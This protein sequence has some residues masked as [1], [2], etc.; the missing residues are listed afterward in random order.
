MGERVNTMTGCV[1]RGVEIRTA[2]VWSRLSFASAVTMSALAAAKAGFWP[3]LSHE[4]VL[5]EVS[6][7]T[8]KVLASVEIIMQGT[9][10]PWILG[11]FLL[12]ASVVILQSGAMAKWL[13]W[14]GVVSAAAFVF[15]SVWL[16]TGNE[17][18]I[19]GMF[20]VAG[21]VGFL[22]WTTGTAISLIRSPSPS[23]S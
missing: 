21:Y 2:G 5:A 6:D 12:G 20:T 18:S 19:F 17:E 1:Y 15:G 4:N 9:V 13:G 16:V 23:P 3:V 10:I 11:V 22:T 14:L 8:V 7:E